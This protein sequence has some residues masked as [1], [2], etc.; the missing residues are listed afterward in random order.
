MIPGFFQSKYF[1]AS[2]IVAVLLVAGAA[3]TYSLT[4]AGNFGSFNGAHRACD[5]IAL[6]GSPIATPAPTDDRSGSTRTVTYLVDLSGAKTA[7]LLAACASVGNVRLEPSTDARAR[8]VFTITGDPGAVADTGVTLALATTASGA[9]QLAAWENHAGVGGTPFNVRGAGVDVSIHMPELGSPDVRASSDVG[10]VLVSQLLVGNV[11]LTSDVGRVRAVGVDITG[12]VTMTSS[13]DDVELRAASI[14]SGH[15]KLQSDV[16]A[17]TA[18]LPP[19]ADIGYDVTAKSDVGSVR[20]E[21]GATELH[22]SKSD[23]AGGDV[24]ARSK[25]YDGKLVR[26]VVDATSN[27]GDVTITAT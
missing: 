3:A 26:V 6:S 7:S 1:L 20:V 10:D 4:D 14:Q 24:H 21:I 19:R 25:D 27:V 17:I 13:V 23:G 11:T 22:D 5:P 9:I 2:G 8:V 18:A 15:V 16:G 12:N